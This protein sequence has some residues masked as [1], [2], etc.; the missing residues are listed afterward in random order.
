MLQSS[1]PAH[2]SAEVVLAVLGEIVENVQVTDG[3]RT[4]SR[5]NQPVD[6]AILF[7]TGVSFVDLGIILTSMDTVLCK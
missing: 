3:R 7:P 2:L 4:V 5:S 6:P 1:H